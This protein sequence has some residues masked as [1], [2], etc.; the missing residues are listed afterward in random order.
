MNKGQVFIATAKVGTQEYLDQLKRLDK[1][2]GK[3]QRQVAVMFVDAPGY[4]SY[5]HRF[6]NIAG[7]VWIHR[8][9]DVVT[10]TILKQG[11]FI[12]NIM[13]EHL[14]AYFEEPVTAV[15]AAAKSLGEL[16]ELY[17]NQPDEHTLHARVGMNWGPVMIKDKGLYGLDASIAGRICSVADLDQILVSPSLEA[18]ISGGNIPVK[19]VQD[20]VLRIDNDE[21]ELYEVI[22]REMKVD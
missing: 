4:I 3:F 18:K 17:E 12:S 20:R 10:Q 16:M 6:G 8:S 15:Q 21:I 9:F 7:L 13:G 5:L 22:W 2:L 19:R 1:E 14:L 11:G